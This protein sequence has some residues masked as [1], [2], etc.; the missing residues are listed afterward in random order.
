VIKKKGEKEQTSQMGVV[1]EKTVGEGMVGASRFGRK[2]PLTRG[3]ILNET[4]V[5]GRLAFTAVR[6]P[7]HLGGVPR[8]APY[9]SRRHPPAPPQEFG[10]QG[11]SLRTLRQLIANEWSGRADLNC[12]SGPL[13]DSRACQESLLIRRDGT[14]LLFRR[15]SAVNVFR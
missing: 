13:T 6:P 2:V 3:T 4:F 15:S 9:S 10:S 11:V 12:R 5:S 14:L 8:V 7:H 1:G